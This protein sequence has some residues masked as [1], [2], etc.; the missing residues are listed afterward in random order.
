MPIISSVYL[1]ECRQ[2]EQSLSVDVKQLLS[3][4]DIIV[5]GKDGSLSE[6]SKLKCSSLHLN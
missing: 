4:L 6:H 5:H 3:K 1:Y 2:S